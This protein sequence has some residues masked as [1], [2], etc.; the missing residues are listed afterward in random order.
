MDVEV[1]APPSTLSPAAEEE[2]APAPV[3]TGRQRTRRMLV[4]GLPLLIIAGGLVTYGLGG[5]YASTDNAYLKEDRI[6]VAAE[7]DGNVRE[8][9]VRENDAVET[10]TVVLVLDDTVSTVAVRQ[11][12]ANLA[13]ARLIV[14]E[15]RAAYHAKRG[16]LEL[17]KS[18]KRYALNEYERQR[19]LARQKLVPASKLDEAEREADVAVGTV[20]VLQLQTDQA[21]ARLGGNAALPTAEHPTVLAAAAELRRAQVDLERSVIAAPRAGI[22]SQLPQVG[23]RLTEGQPAFAIV[24]RKSAWIEANFK[25]TDLEWVRPGQ[26]VTIR[27]D[28][29]P[30]RT[31]K[32]RVQSIAQATG[33]EFSL[34]PPQNASGNWVKVVQRIPVRISIDVEPGDPP[35][36][37]GASAQVEIDLGGH[38]RM[39][40]WFGALR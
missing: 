28:T 7:V 15:L 2:P 18:T 30:G 8:V 1:A 19:Q 34:L 36:R 22:V 31:W 3:L 38:R 35:L 4:L 33:A 40:R 14:E 10:G 29:Y 6:D 20:E 9:R 5:R 26:P 37:S 12:E 21:L 13:N 39:D 25:E 16:E 27:I 11:A 23:D 17:A 32:G 24:A